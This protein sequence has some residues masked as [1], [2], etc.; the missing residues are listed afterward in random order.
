VLFIETIATARRGD[1]REE[2]G[3]E[4]DD[5]SA[6]VR[7]YRRQS[8]WLFVPLAVPLVAVRQRPSHS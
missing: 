6:A 3:V 5:P 2:L 8:F 1:C 7:Q 4:L